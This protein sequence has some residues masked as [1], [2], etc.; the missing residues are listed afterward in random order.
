LARLSVARNLDFESLFPE[1]A[2]RLE[3]IVTF[4]AVLELVRLR[5]V[6]AL[7]GEECGPIVLALAVDDVDA[8]QIESL[9]EYDAAPMPATAGE[10]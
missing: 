1:D 5:A 4:L 6:R 3:V 9:E 2:T 7:Q 8:I 10:G